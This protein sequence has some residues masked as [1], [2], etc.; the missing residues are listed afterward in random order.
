MKTVKYIWI[1]L[2]LITNSQNIFGTAQIPDYLVYKGDTLAIY[3]N[4]LESYFEN[5]IRPESVFEEIGFSST[6]CWRGYVAYWELKN[7]S[8]YLT[9]IEG[10][11]V[12]IKLSSIFSDRKVKNKVFADW[13]NYSILNPYG[14]ELHYVHMGYGS[15][16]EF[17]R[18]FVFSRGILR[19]IKTYDN[20]KSRKSEFTLNPEL[21]KKYI[22]GNIDY[23]NIDEPDKP[24]KV[25]VQ[26]LKVNAQGKIDSVGIIR[27]SDPQR[28]VEALRVVKSIPD[29]DVLYRH[30]ELFNLTWTIPVLFGIKEEEESTTR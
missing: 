12:D 6:D 22:Q 29:W 5:H 25:F 14:K 13:Y 9:R 8:L 3:A 7:D 18:E 26:I 19:E 11:S 15:I 20:S 16:Y 21:L 23:S 10:D 28:N 17:E 27:G 1:F 30:G 4:P 2:F 24:A